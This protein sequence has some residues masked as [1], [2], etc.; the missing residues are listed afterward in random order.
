MTL[1]EFC[2]TLAIDPALFARFLDDPG[3]VAA[4]LSLD[5]KSLAVL[6]SGDREQIE[7]LLR[8]EGGEFCAG[9]IHIMCC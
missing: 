1:A 7:D 9:L 5:G 4:D 2:A 8:N 3:Q 6:L